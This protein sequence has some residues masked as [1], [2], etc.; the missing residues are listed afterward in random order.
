MKTSYVKSLT[1]ALAVAGMVSA[2]PIAFLYNGSQYGIMDITYQ[3]ASSVQVQFTAAGSV[4]GL[5]DF[6]VTGFGFTFAPSYAPGSISVSNPSDALYAN[7]QDALDWIFLA[8]LNAIPNPANTDDVTKDDYLFGVTEGKANNLNPPGIHP[9]Q[10]DAFFL[11]GF[12]GLTADTDLA[13]AIVLTGIRI[14]AIEPGGSSL[15]LT[16]GDVPPVVPPVPEPTTVALMGLGLLGLATA[17]RRRN[18]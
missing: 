16:G 3:S 14:Q 8:N 4:P 13:Q 12:S 15:F 1:L 5:T 11:N 7:D 9:G 2:D 18:K 6:Q 10:T 17:A